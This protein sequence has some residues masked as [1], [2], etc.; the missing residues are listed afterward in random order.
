MHE[1]DEKYKYTQDEYL[2]LLRNSKFG[3]CLRGFGPKC[4]REIELMGLGT[5]PIV[6]TNVDM[7]NYYDPP[8]EKYTLFKFSSPEEDIEI[9]I[10]N[11]SEDQWSKMSIAC[12]NMV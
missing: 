4:N 7:D 6:E 11:C 2:D 10:N 12:R 8:Q 1:P 9:L 3:L 5:V